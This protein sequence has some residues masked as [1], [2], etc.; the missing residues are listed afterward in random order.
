MRKLS[1]AEKI[2]CL[3]TYHLETKNR[4]ISE[5]KLK[6][7][8]GHPPKS[9]Y[10]RIL[11]MLIYGGIEYRPLLKSFDLKNTEKKFYFF[12]EIKTNKLQ[13]QICRDALINKLAF[14]D[15][16]SS[17]DNNHRLS[18]YEFCIC[19]EGHGI[20]THRFWEALYLNCVPIVVK[21]PLIEIIHKNTNLPV[22]I[23][24][25]WNDFSLDKLPDY[26]IFDFTSSV[27]YLD[28]DF[29][30]KIIEKDKI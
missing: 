8:L 29:Y 28:L 18:Q 19:P 16:I 12:F 6:E 13:R 21:N 10:Y 30:R 17:M 1:L 4:H 24:D 25:N 5:R 15:K 23:L 26:K 27:N 22:I 9:T 14:L 7:I 11:K 20:D 2:L 3:V